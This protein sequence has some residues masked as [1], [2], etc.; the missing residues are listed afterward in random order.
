[1]NTRELKK[2][3]VTAVSPNKRLSK[4]ANANFFLVSQKKVV[5][6]Q[7]HFGMVNT[8]I[9]LKIRRDAGVVDRGG[10]ENR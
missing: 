9:V 10:L 1:M 8:C 3:C 7:N 6:L 4:S 2:K 5:S